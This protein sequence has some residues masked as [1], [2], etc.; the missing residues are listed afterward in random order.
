MW[1]AQIYTYKKKFAV[2]IG[3]LQWLLGRFQMWLTY[4]VAVFFAFF[5]I[6][7][8]IWQD[9][10]VRKRFILLWKSLSASRGS[11]RDIQEAL[12]KILKIYVSLSRGSCGRGLSDAPPV[13]CHRDMPSFQACLSMDTS[14]LIVVVG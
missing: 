6:K 10:K 11:K 3:S 5:D 9:L 13:S 14:H 2:D 7:A 1:L 12:K 8:N 4:W